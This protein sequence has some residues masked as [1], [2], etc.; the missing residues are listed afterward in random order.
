MLLMAAVGET[1]VSI[2]SRNRDRARL[3]SHIAEE[4]EKKGTAL[5]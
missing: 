2:Q 1:D 3:H 4:H 5:V